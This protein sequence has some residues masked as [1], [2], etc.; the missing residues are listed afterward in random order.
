MQ[1]AATDSLLDQD[2]F[3]AELAALESAPTPFRTRP[4]QM[5]AQPPARMTEQDEEQSAQIGQAAAAMIF[6]LMMVVGAAA[7]AAVFHGRVTL[8]LA[9]W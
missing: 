5:L 7:A 8:L 9:S 2:D 6:A 1:T 3:L 4:P